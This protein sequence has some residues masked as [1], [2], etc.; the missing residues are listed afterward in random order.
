MT[1]PVTT[2][3]DSLA[4]ELAHAFGETEYLHRYKVCCGKYPQWV[5]EKAFN[6]AQTFPQERIRK[7]RAAIFFYLVKQYAHQP[8]HNSRD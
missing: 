1:T 3:R 6:I 2:E 4:H 8:P 7:S 5:I